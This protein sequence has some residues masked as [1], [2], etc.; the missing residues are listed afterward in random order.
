MKT[1]LLHDTVG[2]FA[3]NKDIARDLREKEILPTLESGNEITLDFDRVAGATQSFI[4]ALISEPIRRY[5][6]EALDRIF[7]KNCN[8]TVQKIITIVSEY[9]QE[10][11]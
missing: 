10:S 11:I 6:N 8:E 5:G 1:I 4:H 2:D 9:M 3:E 7:F